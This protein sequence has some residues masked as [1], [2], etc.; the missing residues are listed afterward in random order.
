M[1]LTRSCLSRLRLPLIHP[2]PTP[3]VRT[4]L[5]SRVVQAFQCAALSSLKYRRN[6]AFS[7]PKQQTAPPQGNLVPTRQRSIVTPFVGIVRHLSTF[8]RPDTFVD[9]PLTEAI[10][11]TSSCFGISISRFVFTFE[12]GATPFYSCNSR[13]VS[14]SR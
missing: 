5:V 12:T 7:T 13:Y 14:K 2:L 10:E 4:T 1:S 3:C 8:R 9:L 11:S 6:R